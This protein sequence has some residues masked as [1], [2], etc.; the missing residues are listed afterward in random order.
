MKILIIGKDERYAFLKDELSKKYS[1][2]LIYDEKSVYDASLDKKKYNILILPM[3]GINDD[4]QIDLDGKVS[5]TSGYFSDFNE[6]L[7]VYTGL[8]SNRLLEL[9][10]DRKVVSFLKDDYVNR[11]NNEITADGII[12]E[13]KRKSKGVKNVCI[14]GYGNIAKLLENKLN[15]YN[16]VFGIKD[17]SDFEKLGN[18]CFFTSDID[19]MKK[20]FSE[21]DYIINTVPE[22]IILPYCLEECS[23]PILDIASYPYGLNQIHKES[24]PNYRIYSKIPA[25]YAPMRASKILLKKIQKEIGE[26]K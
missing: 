25:K 6:K 1:V 13:I 11:A 23:A 21:S 19:M 8:I 20:V 12:D 17:L 14:L 7:I 18:R 15:E 24:Y 16:V 3:S 9:V 22:N 5:I 4:S 26:N 10:S 2:D